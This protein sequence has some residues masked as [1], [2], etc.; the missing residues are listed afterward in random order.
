[1]ALLC[2]LSLFEAHNAMSAPRLEVPANFNPRGALGVQNVQF[3]LELHVDGANPASVDSN[4]G[5]ARQPFKTM[6]RGIKAAFEAQAAGKSVRLCV[7]PGTYRE[8][9]DEPF[10]WGTLNDVKPF[11]PNEPRVLIEATQPHSVVM[12]GADVFSD[13]KPSENGLFTHEW[14]RDMR[15]VVQTKTDWPWYHPLFGRAEGVIINGKVVR[16]VFERSQLKPDRFW[17][18]DNAK[19]V[20]LSPPAGLDP[21]TAKVEMITR[22]KLLQLW[23]K[24]GVTIRGIDFVHAGSV[25]TGNSTYASSVLFAMGADITLEDCRF[26]GNASGALGIL[27]FRDITIRRCTSNDNGFGG[28]GFNAVTN[29]RV[30]DSETSGNHWR[31]AAGWP[32]GWAGNS[33]RAMSVRDVLVRNHVARGN[34]VQAI[35]FDT[36]CARV[37]IDR[38]QLTDNFDHAVYF[39]RNQG[40]L[41]IRNGVIARNGGS[42]IWLSSRNVTLENNIIYD[43]GNSSFH[44]SQPFAQVS[45]AGHDLVTEQMWNAFEGRGSYHLL[46]DNFTMRNNVVAS[47]RRTQPLFNGVN[48]PEL[49]A[50]YR[51]EGNLFWHPSDA[52]P[53]HIMGTGVNFK[54]W[55]EVTAQD[56]NSTFARPGFTAPEKGNFKPVPGSPLLTRAKWPVRRDIAAGQGEFWDLLA[57]HINYQPPFPLALKRDNDLKPLNLQS[58]AN[59]PLWPDLAKDSLPIG[60]GRIFDLPILIGKDPSASCGWIRKRSRSCCRCKRLRSANCEIRR[61]S[62]LVGRVS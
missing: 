5:T 22:H 56:L 9:Y 23:W 18:D 2:G 50:T 25:L 13:W 11:S 57:D 39:E 59:S 38:P 15:S 20:V 52:T 53:F 27:N 58:V 8:E 30:E 26:D 1:M 33:L 60:G 54:R 41:A 34:Y 37:L 28:I 48:N 47:T 51:G 12:T 46:Y 19:Q 35:Y 21:R 36:D 55:Q 3:Q 17:V 44:M 14:T 4:S 43:N 32:F 7:H 10:R 6:T 62:Y 31:G 24:R 16:Q 40:P 61:S 49:Y 42:G 29:V 45:F